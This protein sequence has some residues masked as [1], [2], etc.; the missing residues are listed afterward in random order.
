VAVA[1]ERQHAGVVPDGW[2][3]VVLQA[4]LFAHP[5]FPWRFVAHWAALEGRDVC[6]VAG[7]RTGG[8]VGAAAKVVLVV[9]MAIAHRA[10]P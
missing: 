10:V 9:V 1:G 3:W 7:S 4:V 6:D 2:V 5:L 8:S